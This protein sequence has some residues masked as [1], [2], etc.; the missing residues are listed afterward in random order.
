MTWFRSGLD[1]NPD[2]VPEPPGD[3]N[4]VSLDTSKNVD[5]ESPELR[6]DSDPNGD[7]PS[8]KSGHLNGNSAL[9]MS[10]VTSA[11]GNGHRRSL[12]ELADC[13][14]RGVTIRPT[15]TRAEVLEETNQSVSRGRVSFL[16]RPTSAG[17]TPDEEPTK[18]ILHTDLPSV[19][20]SLYGSGWINTA[21]STQDV[22][23]VNGED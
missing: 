20:P 11:Q 22:R 2:E 16:A 10:L 17:R 15:R 19:V 9:D 1:Q 14:D 7:T 21:S 4:R 12:E 5:D 3:G 23:D 6:E 13:L 18:Q 8:D